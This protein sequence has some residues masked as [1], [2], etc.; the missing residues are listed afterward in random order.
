VVIEALLVVVGPGRPDHDQ[1]HCYRHA[2]T[3]EREAATAVIELL[4][5]GGRTPE[6]CSAVNKRQDNKLDCCI[7]LV[8][9]LN[10]TMMHGLTNLKKNY[11]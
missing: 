9:Y 7:W 11:V 6:T 2:P 4:M 5:M 10:G 3:V 1:R 8:I